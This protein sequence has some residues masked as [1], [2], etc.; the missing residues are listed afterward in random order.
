MFSTVKFS[1]SLPTLMSTSSACTFQAQSLL[2]NKYQTNACSCTILC[3][4]HKRCKTSMRRLISS[5][6]IIVT[7]L[8][9]GPGNDE[10]LVIERSAHSGVILPGTSWHT[11]THNGPTATMV[12][13]IRVMCDDHYYNTTCS[14]FCR[15]RDEKSGHYTCN[16]NG[17]KVC[18]KG[19][20]GSQC[21]IAIC[22]TG[23][24]AIHGSCERPGDCRCGFGWQGELCDQCKPYPGCIHGT[25]K[26]SPWTCDCDLNWGGIL[27]DKDLNTCRQKPCQNKGMCVNNKPDNYTCVCNKGFSGRN[28][29][30]VDDPCSSNPC[31][32]TGSCI[33]TPGGGYVC[34]CSPGWTGDLCDIDIDE[35][36]SNPCWNDGKCHDRVNGFDCLC[37]PGWQGPQCQLDTNICSGR[38]CVHA[39]SCKDLWGD[40]TCIC[41]AGWTGKDCDI[42]IQDCHGQC[43]NGGQCIDLIGGY[44]CLCLPGYDGENCEHD[45]NECESNPCLNG[46]TCHDYIASYTCHCM[47][48]F[49]GDNCQVDTDP[50]TPNPCYNGATCYITNE[51]SG[52]YYC[53]CTPTFTG[54]DCQQRKTII[55][56]N[57][58][59]CT[60]SITNSDIV[61]GVQLL[62]SGICGPHGICTSRPGGRFDCSCADGFTGQFCHENIND[63]SSSPCYN[64][65]TCVDLINSY[66]CICGDGWEGGHC[67][68]NK[69]DCKPNP[70]RNDGLCI[71]LVDG[72][73]CQCTDGW[74]GK[75]C[76]LKDSQ[77]DSF[78]CANGGTCIDLGDTF[79]CKCPN[80]WE[81]N[82]CHTPLRRP[83]DSNP[84]ENN[85]TCVNSGDSFTCICS[86]GF[87]GRT[88]QE[89]VDEC[90]PFPCYN[91]GSCIDGINRYTC[92][93][94]S[95]FSGPDCRVNIN[96][97]LSNP[98]T[99]GSTCIDGIGQ[100]RCICPVGRSGD[101][102]E[103]VA[104]HAPSAQSCLFNRRSFRS[105]STWKYDCNLCTCD[106]GEITCEE[107]RCGPENCAA[108]P[109]VT[110][111]VVPCADDE[112][113][114][115]QKD[116]TC[117]TPP[118]LPW[119]EC[120]AKNSIIATAK[121]Q[122]QFCNYGNNKL[123]HNCA[124]LTLVFDKSKMP[125]GI[126]VEGVCTSILTVAQ[127]HTG[128]NTTAVYIDCQVGTKQTNIIDILLSIE[129]S[130]R[131]Q[132]EVSLRK[133]V[134]G[135]TDVISHGKNQALAA[136]VEVIVETS[137]PEDDN[138]DHTVLIP[139]LCSLIILL[140]CV[141]IILLI[142][143][144]R[145]QSQD[146]RRW[147]KAPDFN[148]ERNNETFENFQNL[149]RYKNP[150]YEKDKMV[151]NRNNRSKQ[152]HDIDQYRHLDSDPD[153]P[154]KSQTR[155]LVHDDFVPG[156][157]E[158]SDC[159]QSKTRVKDINI[160]L[161]KSRYRPHAMSHLV[162]G[163]ELDENEVIV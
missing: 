135:I 1:C 73:V 119:G 4:D 23:C 143:W 82:T 9:K 55:A 94:P 151:G 132:F 138:E 104:G 63:C 34:N 141:A 40:Y 105:G 58:D 47:E 152:Y 15:P 61:G 17:D 29:E 50:C 134:Y 65:G 93:C 11:L 144:H 159:L 20:L 102:C 5:Y 147:R 129:L 76:T 116:V 28:C 160:E 120:Q 123:G 84:C 10:D 64:Y 12:Y 14:K 115:V 31:G 24:H 145:R 21:D 68:I 111:H 33:H 125:L 45:I 35:C 77:C 52:D 114:V 162:P 27:C 127:Y 2:L 100:Y 150:L 142:I 156:A 124:R 44:Y 149:R 38:P 126:T 67:N 60:L 157:N 95:G 103:K 85:G 54:K 108:I 92:D 37:A 46:A 79:T 118:C 90:N 155:L 107:L 86:L 51:I 98:C 89:N 16:A 78:T 122:G 87:K 42:N 36:E 18:I 97:C 146:I 96:E 163:L 25:C 106:D 26:E 8:D 130:T 153:I 117:F 7:A 39:V 161:Q 48:G 19:W 66:Q 99:F 69:N 140:G 148:E 139:L 112:V 137:D 53:Y 113:C 128:Y 32:H 81:G 133:V 22:K 6:T 72:Y 158:W 154:S 75:T 131:S 13:R 59:S 43:E 30:I 110:S 91:G 71:D 121:P 57:V 3:C 70:C 83:C 136:V 41:Q 74:K 109:N 101:E 62:S 56:Q 80:G 88:C 49:S